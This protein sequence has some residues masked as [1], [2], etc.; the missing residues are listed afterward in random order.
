MRATFLGF[1]VSAAEVVPRSLWSMVPQLL[2]RLLRE[3]SASI[4]FEI[5]QDTRPLDVREYALMVIEQRQ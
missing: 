4:L 3:G 5:G 2:A 1:H